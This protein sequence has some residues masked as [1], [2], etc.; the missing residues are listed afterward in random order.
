[1]KFNDKC[2]KCQSE[3]LSY[4]TMELQDNQMLQNVTCGDCGCRF[5]IYSILNWEV[6][7]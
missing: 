4:D 6:E 1:M 2:K 3:K 5:V 7:E